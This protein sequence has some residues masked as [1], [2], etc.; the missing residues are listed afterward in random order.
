M[1]ALGEGGCLKSLGGDVDDRDNNPHRYCGGGNIYERG[2]RAMTT[3]LIIIA[4]LG[5]MDQA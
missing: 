4:T 2:V 1:N 5:V 3:T